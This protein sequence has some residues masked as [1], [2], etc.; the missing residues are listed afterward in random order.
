MKWL[1][2]YYGNLEQMAKTL[3]W[4]FRANLLWLKLYYENLEIFMKRKIKINK[5]IKSDL[6]K[7]PMVE[8][9]WLDIVSD[10]SWQSMDNLKNTK[11]AT[12]ITKGHLLSQTKGITRIFGD[13]SLK[14][15]SKTD[16]EEVGN[17][18][19]IPNSVIVEIKKI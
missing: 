5:K 1:K 11:L 17:T 19:V 9:R 16:I 15:N 6:K 18:T 2:L 8:C 10:A 3:L 12:C 14:D 13:Y 7:Y 4:K